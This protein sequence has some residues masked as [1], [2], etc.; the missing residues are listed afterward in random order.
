MTELV[1]RGLGSEGPGDIVGAFVNEGGVDPDAIGE[2]EVDGSEA[3]VEVGDGAERVIDHLDGGRIGRSEVELAVLDERT[4]AVRE[5]VEEYSGLVERERQA[6]IE[7]HEREIRTLSAREREEAGRAITRL[8]GREEG[9][10]LAGYEMKFTRS[11]SGEPLPETSISVGDLVMLSKQDPT[12]DDNPTGTVTQVTNYSVTVAFDQR[13][14]GFLSGTGLRMDLYAN[15][16]TFQ[17]ML[18]ALESLPT[19]EGALADLRD[20]IVGLEEPDDLAPVDR[21]VDDSLNQSQQM[22]VRRALATDDLHL[23]HGPPGTGK[24][25]TAIEAIRQSVERGDSVL[26]TAP[27]NTAVDN[28][29]ERLHEKGVDVV[30]VGNPA[31][32]TPALRDRTLDSLLED[33]ETYQRSRDCREEAFELLDQQEYLTAPSGRWRRGLS[34]ERIRELADQGRGSR[35]VPPERIEEMASWLDLQAEADELFERADELENQAIEE[36]LDAAEVVCATNSTAGSDVLADRRFDTLVI[37]EATQATEPSC[38][39]PIVRS[40]RVIMAGDHRQLPPTVQSERAAREGLSETLFERLADQYDCRSVLRTQYRM[41][42]RIMG[43]SSERFYDGQ[44]RA[45]E[46][47]A[48]HTLP[49]LDTEVSP[50]YEPIVDPAAPLVYVDTQ[51]DA[52]ERQRADSTSRENPGEASLV[53]DLVAAYVETGI[54]PAEIAV[55]S[56]YD[57][58]TDLIEDELDARLSATADLEVDTVDGFQGREKEVV[59]VSLVRSNDRGSVGFLDEP[60]RF[61]VALTRA[62]RKAIVVGDSETVTAA[63]VY[64][65]FPEYVRDRGRVVPTQ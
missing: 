1:I 52:P 43:F 27:S 34:D 25:T 22:A 38:L 14:P 41:H 31:R 32:V 51:G 29:V 19:A 65:D 12:R 45:D 4:R 55:I 30:R 50:E 26:A 63:P 48:E 24:T 60:R 64:E 53:A 28:L 7:R 8:S 58:Q 49:D 46:S 6:E 16:I 54:D 13:P 9:E 36:I 23:I 61:N 20:V 35:G 40:R 44:I 33:S 2:I 56:P 17:R 11:H 10:S 37:D 18:D 15:D 59:L 5:Y 62:R 3:V 57:D 42:E 47:V 21:E 39:I